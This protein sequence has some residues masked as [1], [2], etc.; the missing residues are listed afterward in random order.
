MF[1]LKFFKTVK[2]LI[3]LIEQDLLLLPTRLMIEEIQ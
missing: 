3:E 2:S 1:T